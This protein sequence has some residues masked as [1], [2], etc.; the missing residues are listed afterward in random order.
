MK[1]IPFPGA[2]SPAL[3]GLGH[4]EKTL[5]VFV[6]KSSGIERVEVVPEPAPVAKELVRS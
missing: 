5:V 6:P 2:P 1:L 4:D 3:L